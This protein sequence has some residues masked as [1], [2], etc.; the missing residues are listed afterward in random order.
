MKIAVLG[1]GNVGVP[2]AKALALGGYDVRLAN[3]RGPDTIRELAASVGAEAASSVDAVR[4]AEAIIITV[5]P[6]SYSAVG[7]VLVDVPEH[8][9]IID[10]GNYHPLRDGQI[11][12]IDDGQVE[13]LWIAEQLGR[14]VAK[15]WN[16]V[17]AMTLAQGGMPAGSPGRIALPVAGDSPR[18]RELAATLTDTT[19]FDPVDIGE[20]D[21]TWRAQPGT[22]AYC[23]ELPREALQAAIDRADR[24]NAP[25]RRDL[26]WRAFQTFGAALERANV[27]RLHRAITLTPDPS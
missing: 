24:S 5:N 4:D 7:R 10:T 16:A 13:A 8:V 2:L 19:G 20:L 15:A 25:T 1:A 9:T 12:A 11:A 14:P 17:L 18:D 23:T 22:S 27:V 21:N 26:C 3:S 6:G